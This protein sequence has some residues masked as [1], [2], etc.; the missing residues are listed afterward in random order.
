MQLSGPAAG[1][2]GI[3]GHLLHLTCATIDRHSDHSLVFIHI[4][5]L[6]DAEYRGTWVFLYDKV[7]LFLFR[8]K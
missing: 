2:S 1:T 7:I 4:I 6:A 3:C 5:H 8:P